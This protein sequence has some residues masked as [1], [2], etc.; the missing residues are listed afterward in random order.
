MHS[1]EKLK[2]KGLGMSTKSKSTD[3]FIEYLEW[4]TKI[5]N[6]W[7]EWKRNIFGL[8][9]VEI[10]DRERQHGREKIGKGNVYCNFD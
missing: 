1:S 8:R 9:R 6:S 2:E 3:A 4:A 10:E 5:V 7:P